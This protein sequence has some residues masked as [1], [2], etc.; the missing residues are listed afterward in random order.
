VTLRVVTF[1]FWST[2]VDGEI[3]PERFTQRAARLQVALVRGGHA[4]SPEEVGAAVDWRRFGE[5]V[6]D[7]ASGLKD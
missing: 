3:T 1:D 7:Y 5:Q 2:L 4:C 6:A